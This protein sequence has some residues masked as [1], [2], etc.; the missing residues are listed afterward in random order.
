LFSLSVFVSVLN[1]SYKEYDEVT[2]DLQA[3]DKGAV[4]KKIPQSKDCSAG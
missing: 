1:N 4:R 3:E 2:M